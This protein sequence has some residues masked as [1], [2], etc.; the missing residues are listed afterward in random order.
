MD[1]TNPSY[2]HQGRP[3]A[4]KSEGRREK[5]LDSALTLFAAHGIAG[6]TIAQIVKNSGDTSAMV[7]YYFGNRED[8][9]DAYCC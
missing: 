3:P 6:T 4:R 2:S 8:L 9:L 5:I 1:K 7:H